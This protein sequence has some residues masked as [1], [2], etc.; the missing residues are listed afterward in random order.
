MVDTVT[1]VTAVWLW[2]WEVG[3]PGPWGLDQRMGAGNLRKC[4]GIQIWCV[5]WPWTLLPRASGH[6]IRIIFNFSWVNHPESGQW[7]WELC[8]GSKGFWKVSSSDLIWDLLPFGEGQQWKGT[9]NCGSSLA[10]ASLSYFLFSSGVPCLP[11]AGLPS[12][13]TFPLVHMIA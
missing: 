6:Q 8:L 13:S 4:L 7:S 2:Q 3:G 1:L 10:N 11:S 9:W 12:I 5:H